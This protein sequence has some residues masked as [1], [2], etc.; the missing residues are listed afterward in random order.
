MF[1]VFDLDF[2]KKHIYFMCKMKRNTEIRKNLFDLAM[3]QNGYFTSSQAKAQGYRYRNFG[4]YV[5]RGHWIRVAKCVY[6]LRNFPVNDDEQYTLWSLWAG[7]KDGIPVGAY[8]YLTALSFYDLSEVIPQKLHMT[9][10]TSLRINKKIPEVL[11]LHKESINMEDL[12]FMRGYAVTKVHKTLLDLAK[13][14]MMEKEH[15]A[16]SIMQALK[17]GYISKNF[18]LDHP[19]FREVIPYLNI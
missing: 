18:V 1:F 3:Y 6:R 10:P 12:E 16:E 19:E 2:C 4:Y 5:S 17:K 11:I 15:F 9:V 14:E 13:T 8:S 7:I